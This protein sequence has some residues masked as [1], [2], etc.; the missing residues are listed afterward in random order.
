VAAHV[1]VYVGQPVYGT[2]WDSGATSMYVAACEGRRSAVN[3][4]FDTTQRHSHSHTV[5]RSTV[6]T[7]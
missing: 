2:V 7:Y 3:A 4:R 5:T 1:G 6:G